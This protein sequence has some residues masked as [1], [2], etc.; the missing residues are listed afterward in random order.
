VIGRAIALAGRRHPY[1]Q[2]P[3]RIGRPDN[4]AGIVDD[5]SSTLGIAWPDE[6]GLRRT[7]VLPM[8]M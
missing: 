8:I 1:L 4:R 2:P 5:A 6:P 7:G 3:R